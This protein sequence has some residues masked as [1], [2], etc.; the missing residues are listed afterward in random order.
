MDLDA[1]R[2]R[3]QHELD[4]LAREQAGLYRAAREDGAALEALKA[5]S[6][7][8]RDL[9]KALMILTAKG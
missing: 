7:K 8:R 2:Q 9:V 6:A 1:D 5:V 3:L 4:D